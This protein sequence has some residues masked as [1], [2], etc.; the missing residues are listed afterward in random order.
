MDTEIKKQSRRRF[1]TWGIASAAVF[2]AVRFMI[3]AKKKKPETVRML[4]QTGELV[5]VDLPILPTSK[6]RITNKELQ[7]WIRK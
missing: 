5:E 4:T 1:I 2:T 6:K 7:N 3:P